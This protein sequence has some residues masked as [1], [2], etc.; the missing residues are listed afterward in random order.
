MGRS[1]HH[2][3]HSDSAV[4]LKAGSR[5]HGV[6]LGFQDITRSPA[7]SETSGKVEKD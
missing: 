2:G 1:K 4:R 6:V 7:D 5:H 3:N